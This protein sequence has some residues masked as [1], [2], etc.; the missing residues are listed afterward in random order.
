[1]PLQVFK[2]QEEAAKVA[3]QQRK[4][5][6]KVKEKEEVIVSQIQAEEE[7]HQRAV[8]ARKVHCLLSFGCCLAVCLMILFKF[9]KSALASP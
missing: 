5:A 8:A 6:A 4:H 2:Q 9:L 1:M 3:H 7:A